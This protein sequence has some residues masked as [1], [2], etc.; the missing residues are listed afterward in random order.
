MKAVCL[1]VYDLLGFATGSWVEEFCFDDVDWLNTESK[2]D[3]W[4]SL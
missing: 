1:P 3:V 2:V 4:T